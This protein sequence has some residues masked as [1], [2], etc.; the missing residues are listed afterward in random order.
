MFHVGL[1]GQP[2][3]CGRTVHSHNSLAP[4]HTGQQHDDQHRFVT[5]SCQ[6]PGITELLDGIPFFN[7][8]LLQGLHGCICHYGTNSAYKFELVH[9]VGV[10]FYFFMV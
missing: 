9:K 8:H 4:S 10:L 3:L 1:L 5:A 6:S 7:K 2:S